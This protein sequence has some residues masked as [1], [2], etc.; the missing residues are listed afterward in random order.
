MFKLNAR[1]LV[2]INVGLRFNSESLE[3]YTVVGA[4]GLMLYLVPHGNGARTVKCSV[5]Q[6]AERLVTLGDKSVRVVELQVDSMSK[7]AVLTLEP[8]KEP[9]TAKKVV[10]FEDEL[11]QY[12]V[13]FDYG[14]FMRSSGRQL[15]RRVL[16]DA[17]KIE[18]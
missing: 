3:G 1:E 5:D 7:S 9:T 16:L 2:G 10:S 14:R 4:K 13:C 12:E 8:L 18:D 17:F 6:V 15:R 11:P